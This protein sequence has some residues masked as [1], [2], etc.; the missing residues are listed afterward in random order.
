MTE[1]CTTVYSKV[2]GR[3]GAQHLWFYKQTLTTTNYLASNFSN[4]KVEQFQKKEKKKEKEEERKRKRRREGGREEEKKR[5]EETAQRRKRKRILNRLFLTLAS[6]EEH[7]L[8]A[9][10]SAPTSDRAAEGKGGEE[11]ADSSS[12]LAKCLAL[13]KCLWGDTH[14]LS[15]LSCLGFI[16]VTASV[17]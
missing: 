10:R 15:Y 6:S 2:E 12:L 16:I 14:L 4:S 1:G 17:S 9:L 13:K 7:G 3:V 5:E 8:I 11:E